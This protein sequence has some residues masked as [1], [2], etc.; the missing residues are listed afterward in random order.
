MKYVYFDVGCVDEAWLAR[1]KAAKAEAEEKLDDK[2]KQNSS[3]E[4]F[5]LAGF[6]TSFRKAGLCHFS[7]KRLFINGLPHKKSS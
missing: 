6:K 4:K 7:K 2:S 3:Q 5:N 1:A